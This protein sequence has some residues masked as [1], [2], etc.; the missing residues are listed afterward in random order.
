MSKNETSSMIPLGFGPHYMIE[1]YGCPKDVLEDMSLL[2]DSIQTITNLIDMTPLGPPIL[3]KVTGENIT[4]PD[5]EG[6]SGIIVFC[7]SHLTIHNFP[8]KGFF[9]ADIFSCKDFDPD[10]VKSFMLETFKPQKFEIHL[11]MR[12]KSFPKSMIK[13]P[14]KLKET[15]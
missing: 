11:V 8:H 1:G 10:V 13:N 15:I 6:I 3:Y 14:L 2:Y 9:I 7:E 12:G 4:Y 5:D